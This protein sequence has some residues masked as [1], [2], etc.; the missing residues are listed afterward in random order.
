[1]RLAGPAEGAGPVQTV[2][3]TEATF[4]KGTVALALRA[5]AVEMHLLDSLNRFLRALQT[6]QASVSPQLE[7]SEVPEAARARERSPGLQ[8]RQLPGEMHSLKSAVAG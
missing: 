1:M 7:A 2:V 6:L 8:A 4:G 3:Q 5:L